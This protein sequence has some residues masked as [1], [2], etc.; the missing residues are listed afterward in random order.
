MNFIDRIRIKRNPNVIDSFSSE[1][2]KNDVVEYAIDC[3]YEFNPDAMEKLIDVHSYKETFKSQREVFKYMKELVLDKSDIESKRNFY[4]LY[5]NF[6]REVEQY[7]NIMQSDYEL[8]N[9][10]IT[11]FD[12]WIN[13]NLRYNMKN[14]IQVI[15][16]KDELIDKLLENHINKLSDNFEFREFAEYIASIK[17]P[18]EIYDKN[19]RNSNIDIAFINTGN[20]ENILELFNNFDEKQFVKYNASIL[21]LIE[22]NIENFIPYLDSLDDAYKSKMKK[23]F[24]TNEIKDKTIKILKENNV[25][26]SENVPRFALDDNSYVLQCV[27]TSSNNITINW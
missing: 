26:Y 4:N 6:G 7:Y 19:I 14:I 12:T 18:N 17:T 23:S 13:T 1:K 8:S 2:L 24:I 16:G 3:G 27:R 22:D 5:S 11:E 20:P 21:Q 10:F 15:D 25:L 9:S